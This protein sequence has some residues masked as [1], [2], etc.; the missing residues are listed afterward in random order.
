MIR[1]GSN[2]PWN[3]SFGS[4]VSSRHDRFKLIGHESDEASELY[5]LEIAA[6]VVE[7]ELR[8]PPVPA[9][10]PP[11]P[12]TVDPILAARS[13]NILPIIWPLRGGRVRACD[14]ISIALKL[15]RKDVSTQRRNRGNS[16]EKL[17]RERARVRARELSVFLLSFR[18]LETEFNKAGFPDPSGNILSLYL[19]PSRPLACKAR[20]F[21]YQSKR[22]NCFVHQT[23]KKNYKET[24]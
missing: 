24:Y 22:R 20:L 12:P 1:L 6:G 19:S 15:E 10:F 14:F 17:R 7:F 5:P 9:F 4:W 3:H 11:D 2:R 16:K 8:E 23:K 13:L 21:T 18:F